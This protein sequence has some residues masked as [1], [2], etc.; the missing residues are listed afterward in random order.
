MAAELV[1]T[2]W[3]Q[4]AVG[5]T[6]GPGVGPWSTPPPALSTT[7]DG[8][9]TE[10]RTVPAPVQAPRVRPARTQPASA[11]VTIPWERAAGALLWPAPVPAPRKRATEQPPAHAPGGARG[12][13]YACDHLCWLVH[14]RGQHTGWTCPISTR[15]ERVVR[16]RVYSACRAASEPWLV[17]AA[18]CHMGGPQTISRAIAGHTSTA[19]RPTLS[20]LPLNTRAAN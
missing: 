16:S 17:A 7:R 13:C 4:T 1:A 14:T 10:V 2:Q 3:G 11:P 18:T 15:G 6:A 5:R 12:S 8:M 19:L 20:P 9:G